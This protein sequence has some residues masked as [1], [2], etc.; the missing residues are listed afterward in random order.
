VHSRP[1]PAAPQVLLCKL[2]DVLD[3]AVPY[4]IGAGT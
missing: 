2:I 4:E 1:P 3:D